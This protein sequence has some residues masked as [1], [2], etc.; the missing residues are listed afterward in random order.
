MRDGLKILF[1]LLSALL[2]HRTAFAAEVIEL[3]PE[4][5]A[6]ES[7][8]PVFDKPVSVKNR[9]VV[10]QDKIDLNFFYGMAMTEPIYDVSKFG[11]AGYYNLNEFHAFGVLFAKNSGGLSK[12]ADQLKAE[13]MDFSVAPKPESTFL[14]DYNAK[15]YY[16]KMSMSKSIVLNTILYGSAGIGMVKFQNKSYPALALGLGQKF[17]FNSHWA[18]RFDLRMY[19]NNAP[20]PFNKA[21]KTTD[22]NYPA[23]YG[24]FE[25]RLT[26]TSN[27]EAGLTYLF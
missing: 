19:A 22:P 23:G 17:F 15:A 13:D 8:L 2:L 18:F 3:P 26:Y 25:E 14:L 9:N 7:V 5:L 11:I 16:G 12:Y 1:V 24:D 20:I 27:L 4:E 6:Q 21:A 10:T